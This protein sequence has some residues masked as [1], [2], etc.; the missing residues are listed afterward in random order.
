VNAS[1]NTNQNRGAG[2]GDNTNNGTVADDTV[3]L[4]VRDR[5]E[6]G[7]TNQGDQGVDNSAN[8][9]RHRRGRAGSSRSE[10][11]SVADSDSNAVSTPTNSG[12]QRNAALIQN[13]SENATELSPDYKNGYEAAL[14]DLGITRDVA[15]SR[16]ANANVRGIL[17]SQYYYS[18]R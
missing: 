13:S 2:D 10:G 4:D 14:R 18:A 16:G 5:S 8:L 7:N 6:G 11:K 17:D 12:Q 1:S 3:V 9:R 15:I